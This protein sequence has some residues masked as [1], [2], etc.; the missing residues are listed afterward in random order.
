MTAGFVIALIAVVF[1]GLGCGAWRAV[2][3]GEAPEREAYWRDR[4]PRTA[5]GRGQGWRR[6]AFPGPSPAVHE[7]VG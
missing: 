5:P 3:T 7:Q 6:Q 2:S 1:V 4:G